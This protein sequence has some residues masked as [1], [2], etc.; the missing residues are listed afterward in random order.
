MFECIEDGRFEL[1]VRH[2]EEFGRKNSDDHVG[3]ASEILPVATKH[4]EDTTA[5]PITPDRT[6][7]YLFTDD[8]RYATV[9]SVFIG[10]ETDRNV[11]VSRGLAV[12]IDIAQAAVTMKAVFVRKH[13]PRIPYPQ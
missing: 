4:F 6:L 10:A 12:A 2:R 11:S 3:I 9:G 8:D 5:D 13:S 7:D 1:L